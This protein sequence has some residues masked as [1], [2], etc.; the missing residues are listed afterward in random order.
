MRLFYASLRKTTCYCLALLPVLLVF[1]A[2]AQKKP[3]P[4]FVTEVVKQEF[5]DRLEALGT[6]RANEGI[7]LT[8]SVTETIRAIHFDDGSRVKTGDILVEM[9][10]QEEHAQLEEAQSTLAEAERQYQRVKSLT[11]TNSAAESLLDQRRREY[12]TAQARLAAIQSRLEDRLIIAPFDGVLGIREISAGALIEPGDVI[13][14]L[15]DDSVMKLDFTVPSTYLDALQPGLAIVA[16]ARALGNAEF[17]GKVSS[18]NFRVDPVTRS[19]LV[20]AKLP[21]PNKSLRPGLLMSV[22]ILKSPREVIVIPEEAVVSEGRRHFVYL[23]EDQVQDG[24]SKT[25]A[26]KVEV[27]LGSRKPGEVEVTEGLQVGQRLVTHGTILVR[28]GSE[29]SI[30]ATDSSNA[31]LPELLQQKPGLN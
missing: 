24:Q 12:E 26:N 19:V 22:E 15:D 3:V 16:K 6:L 27:K 25:I 11:K 8:S 23:V 21:N 1:P 4:V 2:L 20:R 18:V 29:V 13:T 14:T 9:T 28:P 5:V 10:S 31:P 17:A 30:S 7:T